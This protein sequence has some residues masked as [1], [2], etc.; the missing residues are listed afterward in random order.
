M[1]Q[2][3]RLLEDIF[4]PLRCAE[5]KDILR[6]GGLL[7]PQCRKK[8]LERRILL[9]QSFDCPQLDGIC[10][11]YAYEGPIKEALHAAKFLGKKNVP[12]RLGA[13][14]LADCRWQELESCWDMGARQVVIP[15]PTDRTRARERGFE[16]PEGIF[17]PW[18][19]REKLEWQ[20][21]LL[22]IKPTRPQF[23]LGRKERRQN[24]AGC[25]AAF[26]VKRGEEVILVDDIF[27]TGATMNEAAG[28]LKKAGASRVFALALAGGAKL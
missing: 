9:P 7:C 20:P 1:W 13:E 5:C 19:E 24:I 17:R 23:G 10:L 3:F 26:G 22:R 18:A 4:F 16:I 25:F 14:L 21:R 8:Y 6:D 27:T 11:L 2:I 28:A 12:A 15:V